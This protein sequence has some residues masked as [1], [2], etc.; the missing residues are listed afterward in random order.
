MKRNTHSEGTPKPLAGN[1]GHRWQNQKSQYA[2][3]Q[4]CTLCKLH[5]YK[6]GATADWE[7]RAPIPI[8][9]VSRK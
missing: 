4:L 3:S 5:R 2:V 6:A 7:Y 1:C 9:Q 8:G